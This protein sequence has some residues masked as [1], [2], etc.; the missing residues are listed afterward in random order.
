MRELRREVESKKDSGREG[1]NW[2][3]ADGLPAPSS[4]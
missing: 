4:A 2:G 3:G 1:E